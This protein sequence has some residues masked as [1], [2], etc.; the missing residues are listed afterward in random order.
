LTAKEVAPDIAVPGITSVSR[1]GP[2]AICIGTADLAEP[3][4][5]V[6]HFM[7]ILKIETAVTKAS[8]Q[9]EQ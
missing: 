4:P 9:L 6:A 2:Y 8:Y 1:S 5:V 7:E 3:E